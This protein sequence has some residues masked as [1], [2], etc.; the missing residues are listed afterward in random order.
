M[1]PYGRH[2][3][4]DDDIN[5]VVDVLRHG[6]LT[7]G[8]KIDAFETKF[9]ESVGAKYAVAV[10]SAT[11][12]LHLACQ[13]MGITKGDQVIV[14]PNTFVSTSNAV[15]YCGGDVLFVDID[16]V[17]L[18]LSA[19][20]LEEALKRNPKARG[21][22]PVHFGGLPC[23]MEAI[24][25]LASERGLVVIED[26]AHALGAEYAC[27]R[28]VGSCHYSDLTVF[29]L[30]PVKG[31]TSGE[32]GVITTNN[33]AHYKTL[34]RLRSHG[35]C[36]GNFAHPGISKPGTDPLCYP[37]RALSS[38][39]GLNPWYYEMQ[40]LGFNYRMTDFQ[41]ALAL[42]QLKKLSKFI[43]FRRSLAC[44]Y[45]AALASLEY[46]APAQPNDRARSAMHIYPVRI[47]FKAIGLE[48]AE[49]MRKLAERGV[50]TQVHY[51]PVPSQ[52]YYASLGHKQDVCPVANAY[53]EEALTLP[54][55]YGLSDA[56][57]ELVID[58]LKA[59][60]PAQTSRYHAPLT[61]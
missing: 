46:I 11:A 39:G 49:L 34:L 38:N 55:F 29:S 47:D 20:A 14:P 25:K 18:N 42:S 33:H 21:V 52:P 4:D 60:L 12:G 13:T 50:G 53:Y 17:S 3:L 23:D 61:G 41:A 19:T 26:A 5:A 24:A 22:M 30:H 35:I 7:Q 1:I 58:S 32:G 2:F 28:K 15:L 6:W 31:V 37:E 8:P 57:F 40:E 51:I 59:L 43:E 27:G 45:D 54:L 56:D 16:P 10:S 48:R 9:A 44:R 36:K